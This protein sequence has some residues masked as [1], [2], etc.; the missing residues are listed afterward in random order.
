V[1]L[2]YQNQRRNVTTS[3]PQP[4]AGENEMGEYAVRRS[5][6]SSIKIGTCEDM[7]YLRFEDRHRIEPDKNSVNPAIDS[8]A[9]ELRFRIPFPD[10]DGTPIGQYDPYNRGLR[11]YRKVKSQT[12]RPDTHEDFEDKNVIGEPGTIQLRHAESGLLLNVPCYHGMKLPDVSEPMKAFWNGK[13]HAFEISLRC[14]MENGSLKLYP[15]VGCRFCRKI[16]RYTWAEVWD[17]IQPDMQA[18][19]RQYKDATEVNAL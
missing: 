11:L 18:R 1:I 4:A 12:T 15:V 19:F 13:G 6:R 16:W 8:Q 3:K 5:D 14:I 17:Y 2:R 9:A 10:E 7:Y